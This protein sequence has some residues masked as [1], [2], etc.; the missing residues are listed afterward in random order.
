VLGG[1]HSIIQGTIQAS[2]KDLRINHL[3]SEILAG[4]VPN[5]RSDS[6]VGITVAE[7]YFHYPIRFQVM[8]LN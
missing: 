2:A 6:S 3:R 5:T 4:D 7:L 8:V 1:G